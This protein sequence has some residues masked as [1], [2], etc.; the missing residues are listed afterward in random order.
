[1]ELWTR[2]KNDHMELLRAKVWGCPAYVLEPKLQDGKKIPK[3]NKRSHQGQ[4]VGFSKEHSTSIGLIKN[5]KTGYISPQFHVIHDNWFETVPNTGQG[6]MI[7]GVPDNVWSELIETSHDRYVVDEVDEAG[8]PLP[9]PPLHPD[10]NVAAAPEGAAQP[11][12]EG[13]AQ[14]QKDANQPDEPSSMT[15]MVM[16]QLQRKLLAE[17]RGQTD[18][19]RLDS[20]RVITIVD[21]GLH[22]HGSNKERP[23]NLCN[24]LIMLRVENGIVPRNTTTSERRFASKN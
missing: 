15:A 11:A 9:L 1:M 10:W 22:L 20:T 19:L 2:M 7:G 14:Q 8:N 17:L 21:N 24:L 4:F 3:W 18:R 13:A 16:D 23:S 12:P 5:N 6:E